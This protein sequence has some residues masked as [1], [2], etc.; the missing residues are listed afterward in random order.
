MR[1]CLAW[2]KALKNLAMSTGV[3]WTKIQMSDRDVDST[4]STLELNYLAENT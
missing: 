2:L 3:D 4:K 1:Q